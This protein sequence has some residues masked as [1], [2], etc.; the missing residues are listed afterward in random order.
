MS[1]MIAEKIAKILAKAE[2]TNHAA[3]AENLMAKV[4]QMLNEHGLTMAD[5]AQ[6]DREDPVG[7]NHGAAKFWASASYKLHLYA[8][9]ARFYGCEPVYK[10]RGNQFI[11]DLAGRESARI[12][13]VAM[14][15]FIDKQ[16][17]AA[18]RE[19]VKEGHYGTMS[20][21]T[22]A[23]GNALTFRLQGMINYQRRKHEEIREERGFGLV[24]VDQVKAVLEEAFPDMV[25]REC[26]SI[27]TG[28]AASGKAAGISLHRQTTGKS[29][30]MIEK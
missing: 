7:I 25:S 9:L 27:K 1:I 14:V 28:R 17:N 12:T 6:A 30:T 5:V 4:A 24:P 10:R 23:V 16:V 22:R 15:P 29:Q 19:L 21:A 3:E 13:F 20:K 2:S 11:F 18:A 8:Q 26:R